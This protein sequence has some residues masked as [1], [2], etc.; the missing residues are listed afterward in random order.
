MSQEVDGRPVLR[1]ALEDIEKICDWPEPDLQII[2]TTAR[3][4]LDLEENMCEQAIHPTT[5]EKGE[6]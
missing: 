5:Q 3:Y 4:A 1:N 2:R 6:G